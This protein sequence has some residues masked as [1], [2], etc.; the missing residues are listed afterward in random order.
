MRETETKF[1]NVKTRPLERRLKKMDAEFQGEEK[2]IARYYQ[3]PMMEGETKDERESFRMRLKVGA[4]IIEKTVKKRISKNGVRVCDED[5][6]AVQGDSEDFG[7]MHEKLLAQGMVCVREVIKL[8]RAWIKGNTRYEIDSILEPMKLPPLLEIE[9]VTKGQV[10]RASKRLGMNMEKS[11]P[12]S[13][14]KT[15][16]H[17][18]K[19]GVTAQAPELPEVSS[20][21]DYYMNH[22]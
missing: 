7:E 17:Y 16:K 5:E 15:L 18:K 1:L 2:L 22:H 19:Q 13:T 9:A 3:Y 11:K 20:L 21:D 4:G 10:T 12:W 6:I 14:R 8:R